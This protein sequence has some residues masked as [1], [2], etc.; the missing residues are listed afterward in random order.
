MS[1]TGLPLLFN[2]TGPVPTPPA[3]IQQA[4]LAAAAASAPGYTAALPG[5]LIEDISSTD[6]GAL[7]AVDQARVDAI[8]SISPYAANAYILALLGAQ[9]GIPQG[10]PTNG[11]ALVSLSGS[12][13]YAIQAGFLVGDGTNQY[14]VQDSA[15]IPTGGTLSGV[16]VV[17]TNS[18]VF[19]I[20]ANSITQ[21]VSS[22]PSPYAVSV[23]NPLAGNPAES[24]ETV[25]SYRARLLQANQFQLQGAP[26]VLKTLLQ[27]VPGVS[28]RLVSVVQNG[29]KWEVICGGGDPYQVAGAIYA[30]V[31]QIGLLT[32]ST[33]TARNVTV[34]IFD[35]PNTYSVVFVNP[36]QQIVTVDVTWNTT[37]PNFTAS[38]AVNQY[39][40]Q[41]VQ[42]YINSIYVG[43]PINLMVLTEGIQ[44]AVAPVLS[45]NNLT[46]L[47]FTVKY[48]G[49]TQNPT[50]GTS[51][52]P[53]PDSETY[54]YVA[55]TGATS[56]QG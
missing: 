52:I 5:S 41:A 30:G 44:N 53:A 39:I 29:T 26:S 25:E 32:G 12:P 24:A 20:P 9:F 6:V 27:A 33:T 47:I 50:A 3:T 43:Q 28:S 11:N 21:V 8:N 14:A 56:T 1:T 22:V 10:T 46:T 15:V 51:I 55:P 19:A 31:S 36:P 49:V 17:A 35:A 18:N 42:T 48:S 40:I 23:T 34:S 13:G 54:L 4:L 45:P 2:T 7:V 16:Y 37:L 38:T